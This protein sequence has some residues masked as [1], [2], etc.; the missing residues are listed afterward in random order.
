MKELK[1]VPA[2]T[3]TTVK[4][5]TSSIPDHVATNIAQSALA[6]MQRDALRP[7]IQEDFYSWKAERERITAQNPEEECKVQDCIEKSVTACKANAEQV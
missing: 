4:I 3:G 1:T 6:A 5:N 2:D 7:E